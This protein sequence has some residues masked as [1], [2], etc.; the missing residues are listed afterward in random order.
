M[1]KKAALLEIPICG[2]IAVLKR[3]LGCEIFLDVVCSTYNL[4]LH[5]AASL[6]NCAYTTSWLAFCRLD[7]SRSHLGGRKL[8]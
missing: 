4:Y 8:R 6:E 7:T 1:H 2:S 3:S 5:W